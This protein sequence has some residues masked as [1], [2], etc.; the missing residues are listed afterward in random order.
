[1]SATPSSS[2]H[3]HRAALRFDPI[4][5]RR[6]LKYIKWYVILDRSMRRRCR[7]DKS[8]NCHYSWNVGCCTDNGKST[9]HSSIAEC[10]RWPMVESDGTATWKGLKVY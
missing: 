6:S 9:I 8:H 4:R 5:V 1:L 7:S 10:S 2:S 3:H